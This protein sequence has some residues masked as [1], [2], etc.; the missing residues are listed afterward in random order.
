[1][2]T[3]PISSNLLVIESILLI[4]HFVLNQKFLQLLMNMELQNSNG[5][6][7]MKKQ[8]KKKK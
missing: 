3:F 4:N 1:M 8:T 7:G 5:M 2:N 6:S